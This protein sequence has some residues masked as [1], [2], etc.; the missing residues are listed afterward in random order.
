MMIYFGS[1]ERTVTDWTH[2]LDEADPRFKLRNYKAASSQP[3]VIITVGW[4]VE[5]GP[6]S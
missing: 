3:N 4:E 6:V 2:L 1:R 5:R